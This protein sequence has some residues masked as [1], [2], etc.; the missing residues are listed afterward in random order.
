MSLITLLRAA[1]ALRALLTITLCRA[2]VIEARRLLV[3]QCSI[4]GVASVVMP[5]RRL[6]G[7]T[8]HA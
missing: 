6:N 4:C 8:C 7:C 3:V 1:W 5:R 2:L